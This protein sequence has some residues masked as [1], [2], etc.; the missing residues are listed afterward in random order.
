MYKNSDLKLIQKKI[1]ICTTTAIRFMQ[2][3]LVISGQKLM[4]NQI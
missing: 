2:K 4:K 1:G 3:N